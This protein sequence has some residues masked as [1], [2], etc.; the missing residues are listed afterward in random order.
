MFAKIY[1]YRCSLPQPPFVTIHVVLESSFRPHI[2]LSFTNSVK[3][4]SDAHCLQI[5]L[6]TDHTRCSLFSLF[7]LL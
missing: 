4:S 7:V 6:P 3:A 2:H 5:I 1:I